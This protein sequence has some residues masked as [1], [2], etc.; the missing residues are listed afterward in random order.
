MSMTAVLI[1]VAL[2]AALASPVGGLLALWQRPTTLVMSLALG[3]ASGV[4]LAAISFEMLPSALELSSLP[5]GVSGFLAGFAAV[6]G[7]DLAIHRGML[8][9][10]K[11]DQRLAV[12]RFHR[13]HPPQGDE[14]T[15][16]AGGTSVEEI[17]EGLSI[18][19]GVAVR[20]ELGLLV[21]LAI[22]VDNLS[23]ALS[24]GE[25]AWAQQKSKQRP[26][27]RVLG[28]TG[29]IGVSLFSS[30]LVGY[31]IIGWL[32]G[33]ILGFLLA[34]GAGGML[35]LTVTTLLPDAEEYHYQQSAA[36]AL[37]AGFMTIL[38]LG[39][40]TSSVAP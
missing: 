34:S 39:H 23:E 12:R 28:W 13:R 14:V 27:K 10:R 6:Y 35:Y 5:T 8:V 24:I 7:L 19:V 29:L 36:L 16:L 15:V 21:A 11:A 3:F 25:L 17:V 22:V 38:I 31:F 2:A 33:P 20:P 30:V 9:G 1:L 4:L 37:A 40:V 26:V 32:P 18:G